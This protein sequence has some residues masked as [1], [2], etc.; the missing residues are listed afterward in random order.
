ML[1]QISL[2]HVLG[3]WPSINKNQRAT[4]RKSLAMLVVSIRR[5]Y[6]GPQANSNYSELSLLPGQTAFALYP[7]DYRVELSTSPE[8]GIS[9]RFWTTPICPIKFLKT[10]TPTV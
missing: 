7:L 1:A 6:L 5:G 4:A 8:W 3:E 2:A 10:I 9:P